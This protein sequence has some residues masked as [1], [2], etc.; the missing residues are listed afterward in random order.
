MG[1]P[2]C[3][4]TQTQYSRIR[5]FQELP[6]LDHLVS[7]VCTEHWEEPCAVIVPRSCQTSMITDRR[8]GFTNVGILGGSN[9]WLRNP[10]DIKNHLKF[11]QIIRKLGKSKRSRRVHIPTDESVISNP[12]RCNFDGK[13]DFLICWW[14]SPYS[15]SVAT[16]P[17]WMCSGIFDTYSFQFVQK[18]SLCIHQN[19]AKYLKYSGAPTW[20][21][22]FQFG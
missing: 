11:F 1:V 17:I 20:F 7:P 12:K 15:I 4:A 5:A 18:L 16:C 6:T 2:P 22:D 8:F 19:S 9:I 10:W 14:R 3:G 21:R 13:P